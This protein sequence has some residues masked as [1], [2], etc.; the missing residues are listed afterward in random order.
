MS[1]VFCSL[2]KETRS[3]VPTDVAAHYLSRR[4][5]TLRD[6]ASSQRGPANLKPLRICGRLS[7]SVKEIRALLNGMTA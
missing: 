5:Q 1:K 7:W 6:W 4:P 3:H 2:E